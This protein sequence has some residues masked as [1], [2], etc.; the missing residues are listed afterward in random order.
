ML[1]T[2][3]PRGTISGFKQTLRCM[4]CLL[5]LFSAAAAAVGGE[6]GWA[7]GNFSTR[8]EYIFSEEEVENNWI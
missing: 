6:G 7:T 1:E 2:V 4:S 8:A 5:R 3:F